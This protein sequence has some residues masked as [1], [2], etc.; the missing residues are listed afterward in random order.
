MWENRLSEV[1]Q[2][3]PDINAARLPATY[4][5]AKQ[6]LAECTRIDECREWANKAE[7]L[8]SYARMA[9]DD[10]LRQMADRIQARA[11]RRCGELLKLIEPANGANQNIKEGAL[12]NVTRE[13]AASEAGLSEHQRKTA[14]RV[15]NVDD[16]SFNEQV[17]SENP[18]TVT[19]LAAQGTRKL[20]PRPEGF[21][22]ATHLI[23]TVE[24]FSKFCAEN[25]AAHVA[26]GVL[27]HEVQSIR[28]MVAVIDSWMDT[29]VVNLEHSK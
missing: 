26:N 24:R 7:A 2:Y 11:V 13:L 28:E 23:G 29:F 12:P 18:P 5:H 20:P 19:Q 15:A 1:T 6:A 10:T 22:K 4:E 25:G 8:A 3:V 27:P 21:A 9:D 17:E 14:I 16:D